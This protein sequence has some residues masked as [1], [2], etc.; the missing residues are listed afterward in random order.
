M[1]RLEWWTEWPRGPLRTGVVLLAAL[2]AVTAAW[3]YPGVA[4]DLGETATANSRLS[5]ADRE[6]AGGNAVVEDQ[7]AVYEARARIPA[8]ATYHVA[9]GDAFEPES[10]LT[11]PYVASFYLS[12]LIPRRQAEGGPW[13]IC[14][15]CDVD[16]YGS[17]TQ[18]L[19]S[20][21]EGISI[22]RRPG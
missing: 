19:W 9:V 8:D 6:I 15:G 20:N 3:R 10:P 18:V 1:R 4:R 5:Y 11:V 12:F 21:D 17:D 22:L 2:T 14:Y 16:A 13:V 7:S